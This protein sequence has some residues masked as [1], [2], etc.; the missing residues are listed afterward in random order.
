MCA[1]LLSRSRTADRV[2]VLSTWLIGA[3]LILGVELGK[4]NLC[5]NYT[6]SHVHKIYRRMGERPFSR[7]IVTKINWFMKMLQCPID[8]YMECECMNWYEIESI[9]WRN[10]GMVRYGWSK[11][12]RSILFPLVIMLLM[13]GSALLMTY[14]VI[15]SL[16]VSLSPIIGCLDSSI[17]AGSGRHRSHHT[18]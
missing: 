5:D 11:L 6:W 17:F 14:W 10:Y 16:G 12:S 3:M 4:L 15:N 2:S 18:G 7:L 1:T 9:G 13:D 8:E